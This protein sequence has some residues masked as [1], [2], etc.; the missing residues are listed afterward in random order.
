ML[1]GQAGRVALEAFKFF[2][3]N[4]NP[5]HVQAKQVVMAVIL[6]AEDFEAAVTVSDG[7][8]PRLRLTVLDQR[9]VRLLVV[10][11]R[12]RLVATVDVMQVVLLVLLADSLVVALPDVPSLRFFDDCV[13]VGVDFYF[14]QLNGVREPLM[15]S[16][17]L[18][19]MAR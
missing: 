6:V 9:R 12:I 19:I 10:E 11:V 4:V 1:F 13:S 5:E 7:E 8:V 18:E 2:L 17:R 3:V 15:A 16:H 14:V